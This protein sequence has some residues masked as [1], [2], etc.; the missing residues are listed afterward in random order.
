[1]PSL[2]LTRRRDLGELL[3]VALRLWL[4]HL[5]VFAAL[6]FV[7]VAPVTLL[8]DGLWAGTLI[9]D[10]FDTDAAGPLAPSLVSTVLQAPW[11]PRS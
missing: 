1:M 3:G 9:N 5:P 2:D 10:P 8:V 6:A 11:C 7:V 4:G